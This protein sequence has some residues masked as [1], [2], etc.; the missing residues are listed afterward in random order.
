MQ[1]FL[2]QQTLTQSWG[3]GTWWLV[4]SPGLL[5]VPLSLLIG[6]ALPNAKFFFESGPNPGERGAYEIVMLGMGL[7]SLAPFG[8]SMYL[9]SQLEDYRGS[10]VNALVLGI[11]RI[12]LTTGSLA[13]NHLDLPAVARWLGFWLP[14]Q[15]TDI[16]A[17]VRGILHSVDG[18]A[19][20]AFIFL[21]N[22]LPTM[23]GLTTLLFAELMKLIGLDTPA[24]YWITWSLLT[25][26]FLTALGIP[27][28]FEMES[29]DGLASL[30]V[31]DAQVPLV[32]RLADRA[33][34][35]A[36]LAAVFDE[37]TLWR[38]GSG[39]GFENLRYPM[40]AKGLVRIWWER[41]EALEVSHDDHTISLRIDGGTPTVVEL[42]PADLTGTGVRDRLAAA[43]P[44]LQI[45]VI[46][47]GDVPLTFPAALDDP[48]DEHATKAEH[49]AHAADFV[50][51][52]ST[53]DDA[54][55]IRH[56][57]RSMLTTG[58]G[59]AGRS[60]SDLDAIPIVPQQGLADLE[61]SALGLGSELGALLAMGAAPT[62]SDTG[63][64]PAAG[65][66]LPTLAG[67]GEHATEVYQVFRRWNLDDRRVNEWRMLVA[68]GAASERR[69]GGTD[70]HDGLR[71]HATPASY[72]SPA[73][74]GEDLANRM[75]WL[76]LWRA[77]L[78]MAADVT[79]DSSA[80]T[81]QPYTPYVTFADGH[82]AQ[83]TNAQL[84]EA[85]R[86]LLD[87]RP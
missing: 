81:A 74:A 18:R 86:F 51:V 55:V 69:A 44:D 65:G 78:K 15:G 6:K 42:R 9:W 11:L 41:D 1:S 17:L 19:A 68:G 8:W 36:G 84:S 70:Y 71:A 25:I 60:D 50:G 34:N 83:P 4:L 66:H 32:D 24:G 63:I 79:A 26:A 61:S 87:L 37:S 45:E 28:A 52:G 13:T 47:D 7:G 57:P 77:W 85:V 22:L 53:R 3:A 38:E 21:I 40:A 49:D 16:Y 67:A 33:A 80:T 62:I 82:R 23:S 56:T 35:P 54:Y 29:R 27:L 2:Y 31:R 20:D 46:D 39:S 58:F 76:P 64:P 43:L 75:G 72:A 5:A 73:A 12:G 14:M 59:V 48:G 30:F 10:F